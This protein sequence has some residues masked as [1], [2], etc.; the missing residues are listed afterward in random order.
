MGTGTGSRQTIKI[1]RW[2]QMGNGQRTGRAASR[3]RARG[4]RGGKSKLMEGPQASAAGKL[5]MGFS[6][7]SGWQEL[8]KMGHLRRV[9]CCILRGAIK[10]Y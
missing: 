6:G 1:R 5:G 9:N 10:S 3:K 7:S 4:G 8:P 2:P